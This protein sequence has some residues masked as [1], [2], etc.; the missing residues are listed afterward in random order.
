MT[1]LQ[2]MPQEKLAKYCIGLADDVYRRE[3]LPRLG[4]AVYVGAVI[5]SVGA[6]K[7][8]KEKLWFNS[9]VIGVASFPPIVTNWRVLGY[10]D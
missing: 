3:I 6:R 5:G 9:Q 4:Q 2:E 8:S 7:P 10:S 1:N